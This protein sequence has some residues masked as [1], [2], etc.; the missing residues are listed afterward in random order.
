M[1]NTVIQIKYS[2]ATASPSTLNIGELAY[3]Y[4]SGNLFVGNTTSNGAIVIGGSFFTNLVSQ[5]T[6]SNTASAI[7]RRDVNGNFSAS[8]I[9]ANLDG[10]ALTATRWQTARNI[11]VTGDATG[12]VSVDGTAAAA[13]PLVLQNTGVT[14]GTYGGTTV[15][16]VFTVDSKG[17]LTSVT[18]AS[19]SAASTVNAA[20]NTGTGTFTSTLNV[21]GGGS[22]GITTNFV[23]ADDTFLV[24]VDS[25]VV[26]TSGGTISGDLSVTG[27]FTVSGTQTIVNTNTVQTN[28][29]LIKLAANNT[30]SDVLDIGFYGVANTG[31][32]PTYHGLVRQAAGNFFLFKNLVADP[33]G[34]VLAS[35]SVTAQNTATLRA[36]ITGGTVSSLAAA[37]AI[38][39][40]GT[41][42]T[43]FTTGP[44]IYFDGTK[45]A[46]LANVSAVA[47]TYDAATTFTA[48]SS[49]AY[50]RVT[51]V[52]ASNI[53]ISAAQIVSG[54]LGVA[55]GGTG[56]TTFTANGVIFAGITS[57]SPLL[58]VASSTEGHLLTINNT[59]LPSFQMLSGGTF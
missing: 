26:R 33:T 14:S 54:N 4:N 37:I 29:S 43:S 19:I 7:V 48:F 27:N 58:S 36:N 32:T 28:D 15:V 18:N 9:S 24:S 52:T 57:T 12:N 34:N 5:A 31:V 2:T 41:N 49:D 59:G 17:R 42:A 56:N 50:G 21:K 1:A 39:D 35:N 25:T 23:D 16:P 51:G 40:G 22:G 53:A 3:S 55:R 45:Q 38:A 6:S 47:G 13:I 44:I 10:N 20:G 11:G 30:V 46:S 8:Q